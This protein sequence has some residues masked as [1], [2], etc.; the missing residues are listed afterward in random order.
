MYNSDFDHKPPRKI[1]RLLVSIGSGISLAMILGFVVFS[2]HTGI[3]SGLTNLSQAPGSPGIDDFQPRNSCNA[4]PHQPGDSRL[5]IRSGGLNRTFLV[6][7][8]PSY[9]N[10]PQP[11][12]INYHGY[13]GN[14]QDSAQ[15]T[16]MSV[17][18]DKAGFILVFPQGVDSPPSWNAGIG[19]FGPTGDADDVQFTRDLISYFEHNYCIDAHRIYATGYS[20][21]G[22]MA[23][24]IACELS[25]QIAAFATVAGAFYRLP[26]GCNPSRPVPVLEIHGQADRYAPYDGNPYMGMAAVQVFLNFWLAHNNCNATNEVIFQ[27]SDVT[28]IAWPH[29]A[30]GSVVEHYRISDG[31]HTWPGSSPNPGLGYTTH[32]IDANV[33]IWNFFSQFTN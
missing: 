1:R 23:Y 28:A 13:S 14:A 22:G 30:S 10:Q 27:K 17:E 33:V 9:G 32:T 21:G 18:A 20:L 7:L 2:T 24:R 3:L 4:P 25:N 26:G 8:A 6:H 15:H 19:A 29:C 11:L 31:G 12:V 5:S 16:N